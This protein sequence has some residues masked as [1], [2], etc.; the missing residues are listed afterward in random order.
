MGLPSLHEQKATSPQVHALITRNLLDSEMN[1][2]SDWFGVG[3]IRAMVR[4]PLPEAHRAM[5]GRSLRQLRLLAE[6]EEELQRELARIAVDRE[7]V[8]LLMT[9]PGINYYSAVAIVAEIGDVE[10]FPD[11]QHLAS[12]AGLVSRAD[13]SGEQVSQHRRVK[14][15]DRVLKRFLCLALHGI[16]NGG[17][18]TSIG[19]FYAKKEKQIGAAKAQV[20]AARKLS[21][22]IWHMLTYRHAYVEQDEGL[23]ERKADKLDRVAKRPSMMMSATDVEQEAEQLLAKADVL[24]RMTEEAFDDG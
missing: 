16:R 20:A 23:V 17:R 10:R 11:K 18:D 21:A 1:R 13:N 9:I 22:V 14:G 12:Y 15:G 3:G 24:A 5:L 4:L 19:R 8:R 7:D 2:F 6:Q